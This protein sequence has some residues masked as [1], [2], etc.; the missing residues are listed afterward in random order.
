MGG[1]IVCVCVCA[2]VCVCVCVCVCIR[3]A[4]ERHLS[5]CAVMKGCSVGL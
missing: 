3:V 2:Y 1:G 4:V 5:V